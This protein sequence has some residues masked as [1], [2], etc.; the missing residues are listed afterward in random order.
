MSRLV[1]SI[2]L[3]TMCLFNHIASEAGTKL[4]VFHA[5]SLSVPLARIE[6]EFEARYPDIDVL[7]ESGGSTKMARLIRDVGKP[8]DIFI[9]ADYSVID[10]MLVP[11]HATWNIMF[12][13]NQIVL[14][15]TDKSR[16]SSEINESNWPEILLRKGVS[17]GHSDPNLDPCGYRSL[18]VMQLA[19]WYYKRPGLYERLLASRPL[20]NVRPT[21]VELISLLKTGNMDYAWEYLSV[22]VQH[23]LKYIVLPLEINLGSEKYNDI[24]KKASVKVLGTRPGQWIEKR[25]KAC[26]YGATILKN[27]Q[28]MDAALKFMAFLLDPQQGL[29][30]LK[31]MGQPPMIPC[32]TSRKE[33]IPTVPPALRHYLASPQD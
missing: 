1:S 23:S 13:H 32:R 20:K 17:W 6:K 18:M 15:F 21:S 22:A 33:M 19:E 31:E 2:M 10:N 3:F 11:S 9:S 14:C 12:A 5:G 4:V 8:A 7:R 16:F 28:H 29:K 25:G 30:I 26:T 24:Y 27:A